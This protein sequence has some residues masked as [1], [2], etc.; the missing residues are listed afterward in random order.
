MAKPIPKWVQ[1]RV[2]RLWKKYNS[3]ELTFEMIEKIL[4]PM[5]DRNTISVFLNE[6]KKAEWIE[7]KP[8]SEDLRKKIY[9]IKEP[10]IIMR[11]LVQNEN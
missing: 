5:D 1:E 2:S 11:E 6:L 8:S 7:I 10:N 3:K 4:S 9:T